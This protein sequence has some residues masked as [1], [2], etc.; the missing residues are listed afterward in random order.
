MEQARCQ[1][2]RHADR[3]QATHR[4][5]AGEDEGE[6]AGVVD[7]GGYVALA[8]LA[9]GQPRH[10]RLQAHPPCVD[11]QPHTSLDLQPHTSL[12]DQVLQR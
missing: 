4:A 11:S 8:A 2:Y 1:G 3:G 12:E 9:L 10:Q 6:A 5:V 7:V